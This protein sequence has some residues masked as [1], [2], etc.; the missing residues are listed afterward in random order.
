MTADSDTAHL[1][2]TAAAHLDTTAAAHLDTT[3]AAH[4]DTTDTTTDVAISGAG[5]VG[6]TLALLLARRGIR[7]TVLEAK[8][9]L[10][11]HS[12]ATLI[13]PRSLEIL[14][15]AGVLDELVDAGQVYPTLD[16]LRSR[17]HRPL[18]SLDFAGSDDQSATAFALAIPQDRTE[19]ILLSAVRATGLVDVRFGTPLRRFDD[20]GDHVLVTA[21]HGEPHSLRA[22]FLIGADGARSAVREQLGWTLQ[23]TT[24]P[25]R[26]FLADVTVAA[27]AERPTGWL[28][29]VTAPS[30]TLAVRFAEDHGEQTWRL[31]ESA[32]PDQVTEADHAHRA[33]AIAD[34]ILGAGAWRSTL[35]TSAYRKHERRVEQ[36]RAGRI[37]LAGDAAHLN[38]PAGGQGLNTG[39]QDAVSLAWRLA[40]ILNEPGDPDVVLDSYSHERAAAF[41]RDVRPLTDGIERMETLPAWVRRLAFAA[42]GPLRR[43]PLPR[44]V[45][46]R[47]SMLTP[48]PVRSALVTGDTAGRRVPDIRLADGSRIYQR[49]GTGGLLLT[50]D[51]T[52]P[53]GLADD[54]AVARMP[55]GMPRPFSNSAALLVRPDHLLGLSTSRPVTAAQVRT[56]LGR[57]ALSPSTAS[58]PG[59]PGV[60]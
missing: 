2:T 25:T 55:P 33:R 30:F 52:R 57:P 11:T 59:H 51:G 36:Y 28:C 49:L 18:L 31:I 32:I 50:R 3:A 9:R 42:A 1:D 12:R 8:T 29:D 16:I 27:D 46:R 20:T 22:R 17:D 14:T 41:D 15:V 35:W 23:G 40:G 53:T 44:I 19:R 24:Y 43:G 26:A 48:S 4:L 58:A 54:I 60:G 37:V 10:D 45:A 38:S 21:G 5:P 13:T 7:V 47:M 6:L 56:A 34:R 39:L